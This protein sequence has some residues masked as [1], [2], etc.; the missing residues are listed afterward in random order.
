M[1]PEIYFTI[2]PVREFIPVEAGR[3]FRPWRHFR[4]LGR[5]VERLWDRLSEVYIG[6]EP[7]TR[8]QRT[9]S[10]SILDAIWRED[11]NAELIW[12]RRCRHVVMGHRQFMNLHCELSELEAIKPMDA[13][14]PVRFGPLREVPL[15]IH[16]CPWFDGILVLP[17]WDELKERKLW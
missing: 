17:D 7:R 4:W 2:E 14:I 3:R 9:S 11:H 8:M 5:L 13:T 1:V 12:R 6:I 16:L 15:A 10:R